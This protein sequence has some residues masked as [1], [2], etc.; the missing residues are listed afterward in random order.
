MNK[1][2]CFWQIELGQ[3]RKETFCCAKGLNKPCLYNITDIDIDFE[4]GDN[5][6][7][8]IQD[9]QNFIPKERG[10]IKKL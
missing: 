8:Y 3:E 1:P 10:L 4:S 2:F 6:F 7:Q 9:C 5:P